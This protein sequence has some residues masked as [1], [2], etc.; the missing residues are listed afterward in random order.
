MGELRP[1]ARVPGA[2]EKGDLSLKWCGFAL[3][4]LVVSA[5]VIHWGLMRVVKAN[6]EHERVVDKGRSVSTTSVE[7]ANP[8][9][10]PRQDHDRLPGQDLDLMREQEN[11]VFEAMG[12]RRKEATGGEGDWRVPDAVV[13]RVAERMGKGEGPA[14]RPAATRAGAAK[15]TPVQGVDEG[16]G[17]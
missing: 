5:L 12:W 7:L 9:L 11:R 17:R 3:V 4:C 1:A 13:A 16:G 6:L 8:P 14:T 10:Q 15:T 2:Y